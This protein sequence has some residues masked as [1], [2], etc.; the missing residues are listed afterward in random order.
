MGWRSV[1]GPDGEPVNQSDG[2][3]GVEWKT[4]ENGTW[5]V[6]LYNDHGNTI[7]IEGKNLAIDVKVGTDGWTEWMTPEPDQE[8]RCFTIGNVILGKK[9]VGDQYQCHV[10]IEFKDVTV[11]EGRDFNFWSQGPVDVSWDHWF[12][13]NIWNPDFVRLNQAPESEL[14]EFSTTVPITEGVVNSSKF[15]LGFRCDN[16]ASGSFRVR[17]IT[18]VKK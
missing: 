10:V 16:W 15:T 13:G 8:N 2:Y 3:A 12:P 11:T 14:Y 18:I 5:Y 6:E 4:D 1:L 9:E 7:P 17:D